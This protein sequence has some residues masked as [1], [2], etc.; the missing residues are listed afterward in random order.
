[1]QPL[2]YDKSD[3]YIMFLVMV[4]AMLSCLSYVKNMPQVHVFIVLIYSKINYSEEPWVG[5]LWCVVYGIS[6]K[7]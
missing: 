1:M 7:I 6:E 4:L 5:L 2:R 3:S